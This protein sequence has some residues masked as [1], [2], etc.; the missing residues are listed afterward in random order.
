MS[1]LVERNVIKSLILEY[2]EKKNDI[3]KYDDII[4]NI[5]PCVIS[6][7][8]SDH[9]LVDDQGYNRSFDDIFKQEELLV[10]LK[11]SFWS[12]VFE[13]SNI[14]SVM[15]YQKIQE[16]HEQIKSGDLPEFNTENITT[17]VLDL[18]NNKSVYMAEK[19]DNIVK[20]F[21][22]SHKTNIHDQVCEKFILENCYSNDMVNSSKSTIIN[23]LRSVIAQ[24][25]DEKNYQCFSSGKILDFLYN[26]NIGQWM[27]IDGNSF[28]MK[29]FKKGTVHIEIHPEI[30]EKMCVILSSI[31]PLQI[32]NKEK[33]L[34]REKDFKHF[35][36]IS[37]FL[38]LYER[39]LLLHVKLKNNVLREYLRNFNFSE[40]LKNFIREKLNEYSYHIE[41]ESDLKDAD[42]IDMILKSIG[43]SEIVYNKI[44]WYGFNYNPINVIKK[45]AITG[46]I[47]NYKS[48]QFYPTR[49]ELASKAISFLD[50]H[51][52]NVEK[53]LEPSAGQGGL[54]DVIDEK[55]KDKIDCVEISDINQQILTIKGYNVVGGDFIAYSKNKG[56][57]YDRV[58][59]NPPF[60][61]GRAERH[62]IEAFDLL[63][64]NG[65][66]VAIIPASMKGKILTG[67]ATHEYSDI[68]KGEFVSNEKGE[69][70]DF[71]STNVSVVILKMI[72]NVKR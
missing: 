48:F 59:M 24:I 43:G 65:I 8:L 22:K 32:S 4:K 36:L 49:K 12:R 2:E 46:K 69:S 40:E 5:S 29:V 62:V 41:L 47:D 21:S 1:N 16:W 57:I 55:W 60:S 15:P 13:M 18:F 20:S 44:K 31:Y 51:D 66:L 19:I 34:K 35:D 23:E 37:D 42:K 7:A 26:N 56:Q 11:K 39:G 64:E 68:I 52:D 70:Y 33:K 38:D 14:C 54:C 10:K 72:K 9:K 71:N 58:I 28:R 17:T 61:K 6:L 63:K 3:Q 27:F 50:L 67:D 25:K 53:I 45:I 30:V